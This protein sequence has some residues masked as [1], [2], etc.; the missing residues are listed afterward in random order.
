MIALDTS[1]RSE[2]LSLLAGQIVRRRDLEAEGCRALNWAIL[3][4]A[5]LDYETVMDLKQGLNLSDPAANELDL[6]EIESWFFDTT[7]DGP[8]SLQAVAENIDLEP[9]WVRRKVRE[10]RDERLAGGTK[11][12]IPP[13]H[14]AR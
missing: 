1:A 14:A 6:A 11:R 4:R 5:M 10:W 9:N 13:Q 7:L 3:E 2:T 12:L 8:C